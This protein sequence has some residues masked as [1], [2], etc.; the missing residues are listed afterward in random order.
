MKEKYGSGKE[1]VILLHGGAGPQDPTKEGLSRAT[2]ALKKIGRRARKELAAGTPTIQVV[3][4]CLQLLEQDPQFNA[5]VGSALQS[6]G[7]ARLSASLMDGKRQRFSG[8]VSASYISNPSLIAESLQKRKARVL[9]SPGVELLAREMGL[10]VQA[11]LTEKRS[12]RW[13]NT[14]NRENYRPIEESM[15]TVGCLICDD[16]GHLI[17]GS[18]TGGRGFEYPGRVSDT[19]TV[20][21]NYASK[22]AAV[23]VTGK[24]EE[25]VDDAVAA[26]IET[27]VRDGM[28]LKEASHQALLEANK[29]KRSYG[30]ISVD[31]K[32]NWGIAHTTPYLPF[33]IIDKSSITSS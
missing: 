29:L 23:A 22:H 16:S 3:T 12:K 20:A 7:I 24:G 13:L 8:V 28:S 33:A 6:D 9:T 31:K 15:D 2:E 27:R 14:L 18:S 4:L 21:G 5:G 17:A 10:P 30:W 1:F 32:R 25:I 19:S 26:R 11:N